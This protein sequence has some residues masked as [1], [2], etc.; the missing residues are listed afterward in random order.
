M[1]Y[2]SLQ[3][4]GSLGLNVGLEAIWPLFFRFHPCNREGHRSCFYFA[5]MEATNSR[6]VM[7]WEGRPPPPA[8]PVTTTTT[9]TT[10]TTRTTTTRTRI[11]AKLWICL[12]EY[13]SSVFWLFLHTPYIY[14]P[15]W[16]QFLGYFP[17]IT[18]IFHMKPTTTTTWAKIRLRF[19]G[20]SV[21]LKFTNIYNKKN[22]WKLNKKHLNLNTYKQKLFFFKHTPTTPTP[23]FFAKNLSSPLVETS[24]FRPPVAPG[25]VQQGLLRARSRRR[26]AWGHAAPRGRSHWDLRW[27]RRCP[28][29]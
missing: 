13:P 27:R 28:C 2:L 1:I 3:K 19:T 8:T 20:A 25:P 26:S 5:K 10:T 7:R 23:L 15:W 17:N 18:H 16:Y 12:G 9:T 22:I 24:R 4:L 11:K 21:I 29:G 14:T 6:K